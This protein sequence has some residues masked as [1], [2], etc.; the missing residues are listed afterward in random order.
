M[1]IPKH[2]DS[3]VV[4]VLNKEKINLENCTVTGIIGSHEQC[5]S[6]TENDKIHIITKSVTYIRCETCGTVVKEKPN[7]LCHKCAKHL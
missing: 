2:A 6:I 5:Q 1:H 3:D 4:K 7:F